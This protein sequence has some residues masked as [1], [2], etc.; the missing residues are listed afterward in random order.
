MEAQAVTDLP[1]LIEVRW[2]DTTCIAKWVE[3]GELGEWAQEG[4]WECSTVGY[5]LYQD[6]D[7]IVIAARLAL[8]A[9]PT[10]CGLVER[11]PKGVILSTKALT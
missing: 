2:T 11:I 6:E 8:D 7:C 10:Q 5:M 1:G 9:E 3:V 4:G